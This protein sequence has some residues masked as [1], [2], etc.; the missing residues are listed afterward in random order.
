MHSRAAVSAHLR[1]RRSRARTHACPQKAI[2]CTAKEAAAIFAAMDVDSSG[3][4]SREEFV[5]YFSSHSR[6]EAGRKQMLWKLV[7]AEVMRTQSAPHV[8]RAGL[9]F[10]GGSDPTACVVRYCRR[11]RSANSSFLCRCCT[12]TRPAAIFSTASKISFIR[13]PCSVFYKRGPL[14]PVKSGAQIVWGTLAP[15][16]SKPT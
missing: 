12:R 14:P 7:D 16:S 8:C 10:C 9:R 11:G 1:A 15:A 3:G 6:G 5:E 13:R 4:I 2:S